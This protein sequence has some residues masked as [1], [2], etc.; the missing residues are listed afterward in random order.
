MF[1]ELWSD[2]RYR[3]RALVHR[4]A[5]EHELDDE[6]RFHVEREA[7]KYER[8]GMPRGE[9]LRRAHLALGGVELT[10]EQS[11]ETRGTLMLE[12]IWQ[13]VRYAVRRLTRT[14]VFTITAIAT[15]ALGVSGTTAMFSIADTLLLRPLPYPTGD[16]LMVVQTVSGHSTSGTVS[17]YPDYLDWRASQHSFDDMAA[18]AQRNFVLVRKDARRVPAALVSASFFPT[19]GVTAEFGRRFS[20]ADDQ[21]GAPAVMVVSDA[22]ARDEFGDPR[23]AVGQSVVLNGASRAIV[24]VIPDRSRYPS[25]VEVWMPIE[26]GGYDGNHTRRGDRDLEVF[27]ALRPNVSLDA[28]RHD[29]A[30]IATRIAHEYPE[31]NAE[32][33]TMT[34]PL[35]DRYVS[36]ARAALTAMIGATILVLLIA[37]ANVAALQL[38]RAVTRT[39]EIAVRAAIGA[40]GPRIVRQLITENL[41]L[42]LVSGALGAVLALWARNLMARV[43]APNV[44][45]WMTFDLDG[46]ALLFALSMSILTGLAFGIVPTMRLAGVRATDLLRGGVLGSSRARLQRMLVVVEIALSIILVVGAALSLES[47]LRMQQIPLGLDPTGVLAFDVTLQ[48]PRYDT[49]A[50][51][52]TLVASVVDRL[53]SIDGVMSAGA[54]DRM[55]IKGCCSQFS[56]RIEGQTVASGHEPLITG[57]IATSGYFAALGI[58]VVAGRAFTDG[59]DAHAPPVSVINETFARK[60][61]PRGDA[62][63][64]HVNGAMIVG[65]VQDIKQTSLT[66]AP[67]PQFFQPFAQNPWTR[68]TFAVRVRGDPLAVVAQARRAVREVDAAMPVFNV[69][70][71]QRLVEQS[72]LPTRSLGRLLGAF[73][74]IALLLAATGL[75][76]LISF[77]VERRTRELGLRVALGA[78]PGRVARL[79]VREA[80]VLAAIGAVSGIAVAIL[81]ARWL[82]SKLYGVSAMQPAIYVIAAGVLGAAALAASY[83]PARRASRADPMVALR[84]E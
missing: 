22:F 35:R 36:S 60:Y 23:T 62:I 45:A 53:R 65:V 58:H 5:L 38:A 77:L 72:I 46:R 10:K 15:L 71:L 16:R 57:I 55:P 79:V 50:A 21:P 32:V 31:S 24:G 29:L 84:M 56:A 9:A 6:L 48:G 69:Q 25:S 13:D 1:S 76:G 47:V 11:R 67:E 8:V 44:P 27:A 26:T 66:A 78:E 83:G 14:P 40:S 34:T 74:G 43:V 2:L 20:D 54:T 19:F 51:R 82:E 41:L 63:G 61:W 80:S 18:L 33:S 37:C 75:Y 3:V 81:A 52:A 39:R 68:A 4:D 28:A 42:A 30:T 49:P 70:P 7:E 12:T 17:S 59:D 64:H 73:G